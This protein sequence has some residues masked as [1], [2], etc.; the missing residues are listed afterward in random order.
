MD[1]PVG[2]SST[3][4]QNERVLP[5]ISTLTANLPQ[6][7]PSPYGVQHSSKDGSPEQRDSGSSAYSNCVSGYQSY[8][9]SNSSPPNRQS[10]PHPPD[11]NY[12][13]AN[14]GTLSQHSPNF[15]QDPPNLL[16]S[17]TQ[18]YD[19]PQSRNSIDH[20]SR[21]NSVDSRMHSGMNALALNTPSP[22]ASNNASQASLTSNLARERGI[23]QGFHVPR[24][25]NS[26]QPLSPLG[27]RDRNSGSIT[28]QAPAISTNPRPEIYNAENPTYSKA[29]AFPDPEAAPRS[30]SS[31]ATAEGERPSAQLSRRA[32]LAQ[33]FTSSVSQMSQ[34]T[35]LPSGQ[36]G[37]FSQGQLLSVPEGENVTKDPAEL[38][39]T[40]HHSLQHSQVSKLI[41]E[42]DSP[43]G[44]LPYSRT[45][46]LRQTHKLAERKRRSEMKDLFEALRARLPGSAVRSSK[47]EI[48]ARAIETINNLDA[49]VNKLEAMRRDQNSRLENERVME[50]SRHIAHLQAEC[51]SLQAENH[52]LKAQIQRIAEQVKGVSIPSIQAFEREPQRW[53]QPNPF[54]PPDHENPRPLPPLMNGAG[55]S[56]GI[57]PLSSSMNGI[58]YSN[59]SRDPQR[60][61]SS[62]MNGIQYTNGNL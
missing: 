13:Y 10:A 24:L 23:P 57:Q 37:K 38:P 42:P 50:E 46:E 30:S 21:R 58:Q 22:Y 53:N 9:D 11:H 28:K 15:N 18:G 52:E 45:P 4:R 14:G 40:H 48:L 43:N 8:V 59:D 33:S 6:S 16:P 56:H 17:L 61:T 34:D 27:P 3:P 39:G 36:R 54:G 29:W 35:R 7:A 25:S 49:Q 20:E 1:G 31:D 51:Q 26:Q 5:S 47:W 19:G 32:S 55:G 41:G 2:L 44:T 12:Q 60:G 62:A